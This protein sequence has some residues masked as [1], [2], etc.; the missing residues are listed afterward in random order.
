[1]NVL[2]DIGVNLLVAC[3]KCVC[4]GM[5]DQRT[6]VFAPENDTLFTHVPS[7]CMTSLLWQ[8]GQFGWDM[9]E[10]LDAFLWKGCQVSLDHWHDGGPNEALGGAGSTS[11]R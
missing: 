4:A 1:M 8:N 2:I 10:F 3:H 7:V 11:E 9:A 6:F 5:P